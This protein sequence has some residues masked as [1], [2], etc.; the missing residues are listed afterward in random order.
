LLLF[1]VPWWRLT[2]GDDLLQVN[3][4]PVNTN[5]G[6][7][8]AAFTVPLILALNLIS[9]LTFV[10]SGAVMLLYSFVPTKSYAKELLGFSYRKPLYA[11][12]FFVLG[13]VAM[14]SIAGVFGLSVPLMGTANASLPSGL[15][16]GASVSAAV[17]S[18][19]LV[20]FWLAIVAVVL[21]VAARIYHGRVFK[22]Q[23][24]PGSEKSA[25]NLVL[26]QV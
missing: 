22:Q 16:M 6:L 24:I 13:L 2:V 7:F 1:L 4:S 20:S 14:V 18:G 25:Q 8:G 15:I 9:I 21:C 10:A 5:F 3:A 12:V 26:P 11:L 23:A 17:S 19:F